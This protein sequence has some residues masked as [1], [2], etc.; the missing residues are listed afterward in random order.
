MKTLT[1]EWNFKK[2]EYI[3]IDIESL[4][5]TQTVIKP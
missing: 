1:V 2:A 5:K 4:E 3:K